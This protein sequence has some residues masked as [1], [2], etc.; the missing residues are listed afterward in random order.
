MIVDRWFSSVVSDL[1]IVHKVTNDQ[2]KVTLRI[3]QAMNKLMAEFLS[4]KPQTMIAL[5]ATY[6]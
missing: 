3:A 6:G 2:K 1:T 4:L 5:I